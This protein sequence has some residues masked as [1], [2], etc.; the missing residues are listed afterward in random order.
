[1]GFTADTGNFFP[2]GD[3]YEQLKTLAPHTVLIQAKTYYGG[4]LWYDNPADFEKVA[5]I[6]YDADYRG[7]VSLE[8][9]GKEDAMVAVPKSLKV[10]RE[11]FS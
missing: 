7:W 6:F 2:E 1:L 4:G 8:F 10:L 9:E 5:K 3:R 11:A